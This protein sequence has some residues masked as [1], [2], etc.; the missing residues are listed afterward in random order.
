MKSNRTSASLAGRIVNRL[1]EPS[2]KE[3]ENCE[4]VQRRL[5]NEL[6]EPR[7]L[8]S[9]SPA[10]APEVG[11]NSESIEAQEAEYSPAPVAEL[12]EGSSNEDN[13]ADA[14]PSAV[15]TQV[16]L[17]D[18]DLASIVAVAN[19]IWI[20]TGIT[21]EQLDALAGV[22][23]QI[24]ELGGNHLGVANGS[25]ISIDADAAG[26]G[27]W[28]ID[29]SPEDNSEYDILETG[30]LLAVGFA[31]GSFDL[32]TVVL[33][34]QGHILGL[35]DNAEPGADL[36]YGILSLGERRLP[37]ESQAEGAFPGMLIGNHYMEG[38]P[39]TATK[40]DTTAG[41]PAFPGDTIT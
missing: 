30:Q 19:A 8:F 21:A 26:T 37:W 39:I 12:A 25:T 22:S 34:E 1:I 7:V 32:L 4:T 38:A 29:E 6:L 17:S 9:G 35:A 36:M 41:T 15:S 10:P 11:T 18:D 31:S 16:P 40:T 23:Y 20:D 14:E 2:P 3:K 5:E 27:S 28:F 24:S 33:H 13:S